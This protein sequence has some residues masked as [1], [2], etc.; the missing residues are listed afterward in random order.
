MREWNLCPESC[1]LPACYLNP[2]N[3]ALLRKCISKH[4]QGVFRLSHKE[5]CVKLN[6]I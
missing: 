3:I 5:S 2:L 4:F 1:C 6:L